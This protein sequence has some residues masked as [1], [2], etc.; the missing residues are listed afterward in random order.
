MAHSIH[1]SLHQ[2]DSAMHFMADITSRLLY[3]SARLVEAEVAAMGIA[4][5]LATP[6]KDEE[7]TVTED[8][9][10][11]VDVAETDSSLLRLQRCDGFFWSFIDVSTPKF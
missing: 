5:V 9:A 8:A 10:V 11:E 6:F 2:T 3:T 4:T 7:G 1:C